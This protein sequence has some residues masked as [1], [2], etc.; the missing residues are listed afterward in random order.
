MRK[1]LPPICRGPYNSNTRSEGGRYS[2]KVFPF[3][4][5]FLV[6]YEHFVRTDCSSIS[7]KKKNALVD[8][9]NSVTDLLASERRSRVRGSSAYS[10][11]TLNRPWLLVT[12]GTVRTTSTHSGTSGLSAR[13]RR[14]QLLQT[15]CRRVRP[16][17]SII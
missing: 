15:G 5:P 9:Y 17:L 3:K 8:I 13:P 7:A 16:L 4:V 14:E 6:L 1:V 10:K 11:K 2:Q 12:T